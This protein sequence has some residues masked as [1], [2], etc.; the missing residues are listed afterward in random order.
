[1]NSQLIQVNFNYNIPTEEFEKKAASIAEVF[2]NFPGLQWKIWLMNET[3]KEAGGIYLFESREAV[4]NYLNSD[5]FKAIESNR[6]FD[7]V[8]VKIF[9]TLE[10]PGIITRAPLQSVVVE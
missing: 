4:E 8:S 7:L 9:D 5:L 3:R 2:A 6:Y 10:A 1:M